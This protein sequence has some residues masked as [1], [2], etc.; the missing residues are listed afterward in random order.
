[1]KDPFAEVELRQAITPK[2]KLAFEVLDRATKRTETT[3]TLRRAVFLWPN[4]KPVMINLTY[5]LGEE[6]KKPGKDEAPILDTCLKAA[7]AQVLNFERKD[8]LYDGPEFLVN[9]LDG[10]LRPAR[11]VLRLK[12]QVDGSIWDPAREDW[13]DWRNK[14][15][16]EIA[17][18]AK[19]ELPK[20]ER[21]R[22]FFSRILGDLPMLFEEVEEWLK[23]AVGH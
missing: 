20:P 11:E 4:L 23:N 9:A 12:V 21:V 3:V 19:D 7:H 5:A 2:L 10:L 15:K 22:A 14:H 17:I 18:E 1:M 8:P 13:V 6:I 16:G